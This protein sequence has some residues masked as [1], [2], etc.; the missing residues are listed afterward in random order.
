M[1]NMKI[2]KKRKYLIKKE[3]RIIIL[4]QAIGIPINPKRYIIPSWVIKTVVPAAR[5][6]RGVYSS[7]QLR[8]K[9][10]CEKGSRFY[11]RGDTYFTRDVPYLIIVLLNLAKVLHYCR[12]RRRPRQKRDR[13]AITISESCSE[14]ER[15][16]SLNDAG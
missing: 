2:P 10:N 5:E 9:I 12:R 1:K 7:S 16:F 14:I 6:W 13:A 8:K 3:K 15:Q 4:L 11:L